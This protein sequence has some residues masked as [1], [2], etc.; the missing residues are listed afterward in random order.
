MWKALQI[1]LRCLSDCLSKLV[2]CDCMFDEITVRVLLKRLIRLILM[3]HKCI[4][5]ILLHHQYQHWVKKTLKYL[6]FK[7][8]CNNLLYVFPSS[9]LG[10]FSVFF[11]LSILLFILSFTFTSLLLHSA[12]LHFL[13]A[14]LQITACC[15]D[16]SVH[17]CQC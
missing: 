16:S 5:S 13:S 4:K 2:I 15:R 10:I 11:H 12:S 9:F 17:Q 8:T 1:S 14:L 3:F 6:F 7:E